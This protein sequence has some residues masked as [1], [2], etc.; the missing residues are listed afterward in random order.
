MDGP[1]HQLLPGSGLADDQD[2]I[3]LNGNRLDQ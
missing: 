1:S 2:R 3:G